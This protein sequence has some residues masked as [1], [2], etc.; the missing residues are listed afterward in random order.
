MLNLTVSIGESPWEYRRTT[1]TG[2]GHK[3]KYDEYEAKTS[4]RDKRK[5]KGPRTDYRKVVF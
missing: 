5:I 4:S 2:Y 3:Q 1:D